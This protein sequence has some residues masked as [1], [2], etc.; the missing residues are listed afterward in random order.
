LDVKMPISPTALT[1]KDLPPPP[2]GKLGW[3]WTE[4]SQPLSDHM[5]DGSEWPRIS[6][7]TPSYNYGQFLEETIRSV[8]LQGYPNLEYIIMDGGSKDNSVEIIRKYEPWLQ[9][10]VS[11]PDNGQTAA[12]QKGFSKSTGVVW[13]W[14]NSDDILEK[15]ALQK[16]AD[17]FRDNPQA[18]LF[19]GELIFFDEQKQFIEKTFFKSFSE[20]VC[21]WET[22]SCIQPA[23]FMSSS[24]CQEANGF[25]ASLNY[26]MDYYLYTQLALLPG[27]SVCQLNT[28]IAR[29]RMHSLSKTGSKQFPTHHEVLT[30]F[31]N[32]AEK[33]PSLLPKGWQKSRSRFTY[34]VA[35]ASV[36][37]SAEDGVSLYSFVK[38]SLPFLPTIWN[39]RFF[40]SVLLKTLIGLN[41]LR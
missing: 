13:N 15:N 17:A 24:A 19:F 28:P 6:I 29:F 16:V 31:D 40:W 41:P 5:P 37:D 1:I 3:P 18:T 9:Y 4:Q 39:Y 27:F 10:W 38:T 23:I 2:P 32:L 14:L 12:I 11:E 20:L 26:V 21:L 8:L 34:H 25:D 22:W 33:Y 30:V 36:I 7:V 35:L